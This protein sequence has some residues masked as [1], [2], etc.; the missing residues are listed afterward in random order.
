MRRYRRQAA[1]FGLAALAS[2]A[3]CMHLGAGGGAGWS[4][5]ECDDFTLS[6]T[7]I[8]VGR[9]GGTYELG[10]DHLLIFPEGAITTGRMTYDVRSAPAEEG[11]R[12]AGISIEPR[13][14]A[15]VEFPEP[16]TIRISYDGCPFENTRRSLWLMS[17]ETGTWEKVGGAKSQIG[18]YVKADV[19]HFSA[20]AIAM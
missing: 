5:P 4:F 20:F 16:V 15:P 10:N 14:D 11:R 1:W 17:D 2:L 13:G 3:G 19:N 6:D 8:T 7:S 12:I 9:A 18:R